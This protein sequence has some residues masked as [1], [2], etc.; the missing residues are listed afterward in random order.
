ML[1]TPKNKG[2]FV[3]QNE[4]SWMLARTSRSTP[5]FVIEELREIPLGDSDG[6]AAA[7]N[8]LQPKKSPS[9]YLHATVAV[10]SPKRIVRHATLEP[11]RYKEPEYLGEVCTQQFRIEADK[12]LLALLGSEDGMPL[13]LSKT[14][15]KQVLF[16]GLPNE[17]IIA[18]QDAFLAKGIY[19]ERLELGTVAVLGG[20]L[21]YLAGAA[22]KTTTLVLELGAEGTHS[23]IV[24]PDGIE[25]SRPI[26]QGLA[27]MIP[28]VQKELGLKDEESAKKLF[29][30]NTFDFTGMGPILIKRLL[31]ELQSSIGFYEVQ[32]GQS[33][34]QV[35]TT[36]LPANLSWLETSIASALGV[37]PLK[38]DAR[39]WL[40]SK[41]ITLSETLA[42]TTIDPRWFGIF[43]L[44]ASYNPASAENADSAEKKA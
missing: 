29:Y 27:S 1:F 39:A 26:P 22:S 41:Q 34:G 16:C 3:E 38:I 43:S 2:F 36:L 6:L 21:D 31:K 44:M 25:A 7:V 37:G 14:T 5:P 28:V 20:L 18:L 11:K 15:K 40:Q 10:Y 13:D 24:G 33:I 4:H 19:P 42:P 32:T 12:F 17:D 23:Y 8:A 9:G 30:S 35:L